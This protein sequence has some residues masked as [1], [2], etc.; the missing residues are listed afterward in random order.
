[1][2]SHRSLHYTH[3]VTIVVPPPSQSPPP[4]MFRSGG[5]Q[6]AQHVMMSKSYFMVNVWFELEAS[7]SADSHT[8]WQR[9]FV[10]PWSVVQRRPLSFSLFFFRSTKHSL[11]PSPNLPL[12]TYPKRP[13]VH[14][15]RWMILQTLT[16]STQANSRIHF[17]I[18]LALLNSLA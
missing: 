10:P 12:C 17:G 1:M 2:Q 9:P 15:L 3:V 8:L 13:N 4:S 18:R 5:H 11:H 6:H 14:T 16:F 7:G